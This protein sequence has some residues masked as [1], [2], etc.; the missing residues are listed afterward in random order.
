MVK[1]GESNSDAIGNKRTFRVY[2]TSTDS[3]GGGGGGDEGSGM[4]SCLV[5]G[6]E[7]SVSSG[8]IG[9]SQRNFCT[10]QCDTIARVEPI[11]MVM[12]RLEWFGHGNET[13]N[14]KAVVRMKM[15][16]KRPRGRSTLRWKDIVRRD[17]K[18][19]NIREEWTTDSER[20]KGLCKTL[21]A[22]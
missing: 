22:R 11:A 3:R 19:L 17:L 9:G 7:S 10:T 4:S 5:P 12:R 16:R 13:E 15:E 18:A 2:P 20:W 8:S 21:C 6:S 1:K 14:I